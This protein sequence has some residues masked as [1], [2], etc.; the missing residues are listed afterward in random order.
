MYGPC[1]MYAIRPPEYFPGLPF[2]AL[3]LRCD[4]FLL[5]ESFQYSRQTFQNRAR[6][7]NPTGWQW[8]TVP[9]KGRQH[10]RAIRDVEIDNTVPW[11]GKHFRA[12]TF[13][14]RSTP[15]F[16][17]YEERF[18][19]LYEQDWPRL[20]PLTVASIRL[21]ARLMSLD[22]PEV[23]PERDEKAEPPPASELLLESDPPDLQGA[24]LR[25]NEPEYHQN[26]EGFEPGM[27]ILDLLFNHGPD[28][29]SLIEGGIIYPPDPRNNG[30]GP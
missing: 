24:R 27:S 7:R 12:L 14:Y 9:L 17:F 22:A 15:Y 8:L 20:G 5:A 19:G 13:N 23:L 6:I 2:W 3:M 10:G 25:F 11:R 1:L 26:F 16:E 21:V 29:K 30:S 28:A 18:A 4:R